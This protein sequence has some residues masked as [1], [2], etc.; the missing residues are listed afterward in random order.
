MLFLRKLLPTNFLFLRKKLTSEWLT[1][2][3]ARSPI[4]EASGTLSLMSQQLQ[5][6]T[7]KHCRFVVCIVRPLRTVQSVLLWHPIAGCGRILDI[8]RWPGYLV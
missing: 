8:D 6:Q 5:I 3:Y 2:I 1:I 7:M 4:L